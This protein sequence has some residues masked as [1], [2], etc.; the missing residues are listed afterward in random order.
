MNA[1]APRTALHSGGRFSRP[2]ARI[3]A[4]C[5]AT[6]VAAALFAC[7]PGDPGRRPCVL[8]IVVDTLRADRLGCYGWS[9]NTSPSIDRLAAEGVLADKMLCHVPQTLPSFCSILTGSHPV[10]HGVRANGI[11]AL[12][13]SAETLAERFRAAGYRTAAV[14]AGFP[15]DSMFGL[16]QG[17]DEYFDEMKSIRSAAGQK[18][19]TDG[20]VKWLSHRPENFE[21]TADQVTPQALEWLSDDSNRP[22]F[23]M[24]H[25]FDPH[26]D[27]VPPPE[28]ARSFDH[29]YSG[30][31]AFVDEHVGRLLAGLEKL[32]LA[33]DTL[34]VFTA[35][36]GECL[37]EFGRKEH[38]NQL[39]Q[40]ALHVP[41]IMRMPG[42]VPAGGRI[43]GLSRSVDVMPTVLELAGL[44][45]PDA[46]Q[47]TSLVPAIGAGRTETGLSYFETLFGVLEVDAGQSQQG[48]T[49]GKWKFIHVTKQDR[50]AGKRSSLVG[51]FDLENDANERNNLA[52]ERP[53]LVKKYNDILSDFLEAHPAG[54]AEPLAP[55]ETSIEKLKSLGYF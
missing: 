52:S 50:D 6:A 53:D 8:L 16:G 14:I 4:L 51:L 45:V 34:V 49:D 48:V 15:L 40:A 7:D 11:F 36:H 2:A 27:Y 1:I 23:M 47:G 21:S 22:F 20:K 12:P 13:S 18:R 42:T 41:F 32:G 35:D 30:E 37:G 10:S 9:E 54:R 46:V 43:A 17:F 33:D 19:G 38:Q 39:W 55:D 28:Y 31:V 44:P 5:L 26:D 25:Y 24:V 29:P 3:P